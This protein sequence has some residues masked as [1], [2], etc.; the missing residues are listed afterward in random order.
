MKDS[1]IISGNMLLETLLQET[2][3]MV[4]KHTSMQK[5]LILLHNQGQWIAKAQ[6]NRDDNNVFLFQSMDIHPFDS[7][8]HLV[9]MAIV[10]HV[11]K[12]KEP[13][14]LANASHQGLFTKDPYI[15]ENQIKSVLCSPLIYQENLKGILYLENHRI[16]AQFP[17]DCFEMLQLF[18]SQIAL[19]LE[20][21]ERYTQLEQQKIE[22]AQQLEQTHEKIHLLEKKNREHL[23]FG[24]LAHEVRNTIVGSKL[25]AEQILGK[26]Q[27]Q[28]T[29][30]HLQNSR[31]LKELSSYL[32]EHTNPEVFYSSLAILQPIL[33]NE[34]HVENALR[35]IYDAFTRSLFITEQ[36]INF[37]KI[38]HISE[39]IENISIHS[40]LT[41]LVKELEM[42]TQ[43]NHIQISIE[44]AENDFSLQGNSSHLYSIFH[45][46]IR[47]A[48]EALLTSSTHHH[49]S[50]RIQI[51]SLD[52]DAY[53]S[54]LV[55]D[56][57]IGIPKKDLQQIYTPF[58][59]T[60]SN[61]GTGLGLGYVKKILSLYQGKIEVESIEGK[62]T[63]FRISFPKKPVFAKF[64][65]Q[66]LPL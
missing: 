11:E 44:L 45:N 65:S 8:S 19:S 58:F 7:E 38:G 50:S 17:T 5:G 18:S 27:N 53:F 13:L 36:M 31:K 59:S 64:N 43:E 52:E 4:M 23:T 3:E 40:I 63:T 16:T 22:Q 51:R 28:F 9:S 34:E 32:Q 54:V 41:N 62:G 66:D 39:K 57:G 2:L 29:S 37:S 42:E 25:I 35:I 30:L 48:K 12:T 10:K 20:N 24:E 55:E 21:L 1:H 47:N 6:G 61:T 46:L 49:A 56:N 14:A 60:K 26:E 15:L 33:N